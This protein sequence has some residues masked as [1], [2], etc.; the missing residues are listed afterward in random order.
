MKWSSSFLA[1]AVTIVLNLA[2]GAGK[3]SKPDK[4]RY[5]LVAV[6]STTECAAILDVTLRLKLVPAD[7]HADGKAM[8]ER[9]AA[10][11]VKLAKA[12]EA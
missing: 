8:L 11:L 10:M 12:Q 2:E 9:I 7:R 3:F 5:Y 6:G 4:R 1:D